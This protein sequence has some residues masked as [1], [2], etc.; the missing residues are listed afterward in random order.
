MRTPLAVRPLRWL[1]V[2]GLVTLVSARAADVDSLVRAL[3]D[4]DRTADELT[5][6][7]QKAIDEGDLDIL[8]MAL[9]AYKQANGIAFEK[10]V[11][12]QKKPQP[13]RPA[14]RAGEQVNSRSH[15][16]KG[17]RYN[18]PKLYQ[19]EN[20][21]GRKIDPHLVGGILQGR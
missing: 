12:G 5:E 20:A 13:R 6:Q 14:D 9:Q 17:H 4:P 3:R 10:P 7:V 16:A 19:E 1:I 15:A 2:L 11:K 18:G 21:F 8:D